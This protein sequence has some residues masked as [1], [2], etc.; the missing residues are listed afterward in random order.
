MAEPLQFKVFF[1]LLK[2]N[3]SLEKRQE[4]RGGMERRGEGT[5]SLSQRPQAVVGETRKF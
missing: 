1:F 5:G 2:R 4:R 3:S